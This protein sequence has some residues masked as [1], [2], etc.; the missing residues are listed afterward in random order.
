M[1]TKWCFKL[2]QYFKLCIELEFILRV[3]VSIALVIVPLTLFKTGIWYFLFNL[4]L[5]LFNIASVM[6]WKTATSCI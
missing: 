3:G 5:V 4:I 6:K 1:F 2:N